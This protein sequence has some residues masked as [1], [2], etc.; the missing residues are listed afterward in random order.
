MICPGVL[1]PVLNQPMI[2]NI[3]CIPFKL[4][5]LLSY[6]TLRYLRTFTADIPGSFL[7]SSGVVLSG[8]IIY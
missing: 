7:P 2:R 1:K 4:N 8:A 5:A 6:N 3:I